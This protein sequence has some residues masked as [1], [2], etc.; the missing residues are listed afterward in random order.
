MAP[1]KFELQRMASEHQKMMQ[2]VTGRPLP[3]KVPSKA[4][5][6]K[7]S[8]KLKRDIAKSKLEL[9]IRKA[10]DWLKTLERVQRNLCLQPR[11]Q[12][13]GED[14]SKRPAIERERAAQTDRGARLVLEIL[15][16]ERIVEGLKKSYRLIYDV[17]YGS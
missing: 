13:D 9:R 4:E 16:Q 12:W 17:E 11:P 2:Q 15:K 8:A 7:L 14:W 10:A 5:R 6:E 1:T 3:P